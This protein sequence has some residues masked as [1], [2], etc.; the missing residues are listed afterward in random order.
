MP[1][2]GAVTETQ[3]RRAGDICIPRKLGHCGAVFVLRIA[4]QL[5]AKLLKPKERGSFETFW[6]DK[7]AIRAAFVGGSALGTRSPL[8][9]V[10]ALPDFPSALGP[11]AFLFRGESQ[12]PPRRC[13]KLYFHY[14]ESQR[15]LPARVPLHLDLQPLRALGPDSAQDPLPASLCLG[16]CHFQAAEVPAADNNCL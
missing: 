14:L 12:C 16:G 9:S 1:A 13:F 10:S 4:R 15:E 7:Q 3:L 8:P 11:W 6:H 5:P 2:L